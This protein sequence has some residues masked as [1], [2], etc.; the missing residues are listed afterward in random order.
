M[1]SPSPTSVS[2]LPPS[3]IELPPQTLTTKGSLDDLFARL[4]GASP[5]IPS[6][7]AEELSPA[8][9]DKSLF[10]FDESS[11][12]GMATIKTSADAT[13]PGDQ[14]SPARLFAEPSY[15]QPGL[16]SPQA[17]RT[18]DLTDTTQ[19][20][21]EQ[22]YLR[23]AAEYFVAISPGTNTDVQTIQAVAKKLHVA[24]DSKLAKLQLGEIEELRARYVFAVVSYINKTAKLNLEP[25]TTDFVKTV[26]H[27]SNGDFM[28]LCTALVEE[29]HIALDS[30]E[31]VAGLCKNILDIL[32]KA[33]GLLAAQLRTIR[34]ETTKTVPSRPKSPVA[35]N[36]TP[37]DQLDGM[38][39]WPQ[40]ETREHGMYWFKVSGRLV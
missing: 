32:P 13:L 22:K 40:Q 15:H 12:T 35:A 33:D 31:H 17:Q 5:P 29:G 27:D 19:E 10:S 28:Q 6:R 1:K 36:E 30:L 8:G 21:P 16:G 3:K 18:A 38:K 7:P 39:A 11:T 37:V 23:K 26:L 2:K 4:S 25:L 24:Y 34:A 9:P 14:A 20:E